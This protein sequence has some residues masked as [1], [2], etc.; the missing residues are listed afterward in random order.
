MNDTIKRSSTL[1]IFTRYPEPGKTKTRLIPLL[2]EVEAARLQRYMTERTVSLGRQLQVNLEIHFFGGN[3]QLMA[4]WLGRDLTYQEQIEGDLGAKMK[5]AFARAI[6]QGSQKTIIIGT[7]CPDLDLAI[8][9]LAFQK[10]KD[11]ELVFGPTEDGGYYLIGLRQIVPQLFDNIP[12]GTEKVL[13]TTINAISSLNVS[14]S[15]LEP[16]Q[17]LDRPEDFQGFFNSGKLSFFSSK[18]SKET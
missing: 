11:S 4:N 15:Y 9:N 7:D 14:Y 12:W 18:D 16:L 17:D 8:L 13:A 2:G 10:L 5:A 3:R 6:C 1:I